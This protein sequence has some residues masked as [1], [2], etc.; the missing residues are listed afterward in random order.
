MVAI[1][2]KSDAARGFEQIIDFLSGSYINHALT[3]N[4][5]VYI[6]C[7]K[8]FW[9][10]AVVK[11]LGDVTSA[12]RTSW[13]EFSSAMASVLICLSSGQRRK[14][15]ITEDIVR[16]A[17]HLDDVKSIDCLPNEEIFVELARMGRMHPNRGIIAE[18]D[19]DEDVIL[20]E[21]NVEKNAE[22]DEKDAV[23]QG[24]LEESQAQ[25]Y[26]TDL[27]HADKVLSMQDDKPEPV[28]LKEV[29]E[30][31]TTAKLMT[32]V[33]TAATTTITVAPSATRRRKGVVIRDPKETA[34]P[35][36]IIHSELKS[37]DKRKGIMVQEPKPLKKQAQI[38][39]D[40]TCA[41]ELKAKLNKNIN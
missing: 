36:T 18:I 9:N 17:L 5:H 33:V 31:V 25:V 24:R 16:Q 12:K 40:K 35:S 22:V 23:V 13:N 32:E 1:L 3:V 8:Q 41:R 14:V 27:G 4:P 34:T 30:V 15:V 37:K 28:K 7:I 38:E 19:A 39:Q 10:I 26:H 29:I 11:R 21:V 2:E 20:E 6:S